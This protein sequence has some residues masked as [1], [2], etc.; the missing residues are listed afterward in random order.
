MS[1]TSASGASVLV[2][3]HNPE[4]FERQNPFQYGSKALML[5]IVHSHY[6]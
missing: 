6:L 4:L 2:G 1:E 3:N 5:I